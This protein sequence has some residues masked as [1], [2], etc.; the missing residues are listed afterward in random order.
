MDDAYVVGL[1][2]GEGSFVISIV[3]SRWYSNKTNN[4]RAKLI[5]SLSLHKADIEL[6]K[7][8][9][10]FFKCGSIYSARN[11]ALYV[12]ENLN[13]IKEKIIPFFD[14]HNLIGKKWKDYL[15][16]KKA[17]KLF[18]EKQHHSLDGLKKIEKIRENMNPH[19]ANRRVIRFP[20]ASH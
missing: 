2:E 16:W 3:K 6:L 13:D 11:E 20:E 17:A 4:L 1:C 19:R 7:K 18:F 15:L 5:F 10:S 14:S 12:V 8:L 9:Q